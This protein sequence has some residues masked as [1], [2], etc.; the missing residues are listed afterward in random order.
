MFTMHIRAYKPTVM[1]FGLTNSF[2]TFQT[3]MNDLFQD[4]IN[5]ENMATFINNIIVTIDTEEEHD[6]LI[7]EILERL[8]END[9][10]IKLE[11]CQ[12]KVR[13]VKFLGVVIGL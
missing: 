7:E 4:M 13:E 2:A 9:L 5:Q 6:E 1:Y 11:K 12:W 3:I 10:F 8:K